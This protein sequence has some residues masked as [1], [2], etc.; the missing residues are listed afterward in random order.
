MNVPTLRGNDIEVP[1]RSGMQW[2][3]KYLSSRV[4]SM[5]M[6][7]A[8]V[9][10]TTGHP[11]TDQRLA[12][13]NNWL[14]FRQNF[15]NR[16][17]TGSQ[18]GQLTRQWYVTVNSV[19]SLLSATALGELGSDLSPTMTGR[20][21]ATFSVDIN[22]A[23]PYFYGVQQNQTLTYN[24]AATVNN[25][26]EGVVGE[27][28]GDGFACVLHGPLTNPTVSNLSA[29]VSFTYNGTIASGHLVTVDLVNFTAVD[30]SSINQI[31]KITHAGSR[32][33]LA[34]LGGLNGANSCKLT[35][36][37]GADTGTAVLTWSPPYL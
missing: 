37:N 23:D 30:D 1:Y 12:W 35:S 32:M 33:W 9:D 22:L 3:P 34:L 10:Q 13:N 20:T 19:T 17:V 14:L 25:L 29:G 16:G 2:R 5:V 15:F 6:W 26:G 11:A 7:L 21:R 31:A 24:N 36:T 27:N 28:F 18:L 4:V 8:G